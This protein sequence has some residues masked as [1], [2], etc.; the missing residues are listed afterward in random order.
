MAESSSTGAPLK[1]YAAES[2]TGHYKRFHFYD[3]CERTAWPI[4]IFHGI[5]DIQYYTCTSNRQQP[6]KKSVY[7]RPSSSFHGWE[8]RNYSRCGLLENECNCQWFTSFGLGT[9]RHVFYVTYTSFGSR[10]VIAE[11]SLLD[12]DHVDL[13]RSFNT[14]DERH[15]YN[16]KDCKVSRYRLIRSW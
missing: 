4:V 11:S 2:Q 5:F 13:Q 8:Y 16:S 10:S 12:V 15:A 7:F 9:S 6:K 1:I 14:N 3:L